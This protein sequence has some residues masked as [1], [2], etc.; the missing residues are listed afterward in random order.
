M[1]AELGA[2]GPL[3]HVGCDKT[4]KFLPLRFEFLFGEHRRHSGRAGD[5][6]WRPRLG[7]ERGKQGSPRLGHGQIRGLAPALLVKN[8][9]LREEHGTLDIL[10]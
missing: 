8:L 4:R 5:W 6:W 3:C 10:R 2:I 9:G 1:K 7:D